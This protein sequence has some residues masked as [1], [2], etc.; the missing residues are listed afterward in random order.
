MT[1]IESRNLSA[2][3]EVGPE[4]IG[5]QPAD[6][7]EKIEAQDQT[8]LFFDRYDGSIK[9]YGAETSLTIVLIDPARAGVDQPESWAIDLEQGVIYADPKFFLER[10]YELADSQFA[11][12]HEV[13]HFRELRD[14]LNEQDG[15]QVW[16]K[17]RR[18]V[19][20]FRRLRLLDNC[21]DDIRMNRTVI[22]RAPS[23][24]T[25]R[26][27]LYRDKLFPNSDLRKLP[28]HLQF[29]YTV[30]REWEVAGETCIISDEV[31]EAIELINET[32]DRSGRS[33]TD[34]TTIP[35]LPTSQRLKL[36]DSFF[37][38]I[39]EK[40]F[41]EDVV[42]WSDRVPPSGS[43]EG[44]QGNSDSESDG[45]TQPEGPAVP[46]NPE[47][48]FKEY[49]DDF[50]ANSP[51]AAIDQDDI[52][53]ILEQYAKDNGLDLPPD[54]RNEA[55]Y[56]RAEGV[57]VGD[58]RSYRRL[59]EQVSQLRDPETNEL[60]IDQLRAIFHRIIAERTR[61]RRVPYAPQREGEVLINP[62]QAYADVVAG[63]EES[64]AWLTH[65]T[66][67]RPA[68]R[69]GQFDITLICDR[70]SSMQ[71]GQ[72]GRDQLCSAV[73]LME[74][75]KEFSDELD[76]A[77][78][79]LE[80]DLQVRAEVRSFG[81]GDA[82]HDILKPLGSDLSERQRVAVAKALREL[83]G[84]TP[85]YLPLEDVLNTTSEEDWTKIAAGQLRN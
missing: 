49:Y 15:Y 12:F 55:A 53:K 72:K 58:L 51:D 22:N 41:Q 33:V 82:H 61:S 65:Q 20:S 67:E 81:A 14:L 46:A 69:F 8:K 18:R 66:K 31:R 60:V 7:G 79:D 19:K 11:V 64:E 34:I 84:S 27:H 68:E 50:F 23:L 3:E 62:V 32:R 71:V 75:L 47:D 36:Q 10:E 38:P 48:I 83:P 26:S 13:E 42:E 45:E 28:K 2:V 56:A 25:A 77:R 78:I 37:V 1:E 52:N 39:Y 17:H 57:T 6:G 30:L 85:D 70:S 4:D 5:E 35:Q 63:K 80:T 54:S 29:A 59:W 43:E 24:E 74:A 9:R 73:L 40:F 16:Q 21:V 76:E 44:G